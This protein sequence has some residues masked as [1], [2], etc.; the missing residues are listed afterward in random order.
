MTRRWDKYKSIP[1]FNGLIFHYLEELYS[2]Y[3]EH[4]LQETRDKHDVTDGL[5]RHNHALNDSLKCIEIWQL[6]L[7]IIV[8]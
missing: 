6:V 7:M 5:D 8:I 2:Y 4:E 3:G 1:N